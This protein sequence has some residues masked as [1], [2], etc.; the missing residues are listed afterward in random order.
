MAHIALPVEVVTRSIANPDKVPKRRRI[1][2]RSNKDRKWLSGHNYWCALN[3]HTVT[4]SP[5]NADD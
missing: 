1:D 2:L 4:V 3:A 5:V